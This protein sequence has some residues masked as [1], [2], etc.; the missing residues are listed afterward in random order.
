M[1]SVL[2]N[3]RK[4]KVTVFTL[5]VI[6]LVLALYFFKL[7]FSPFAFFLCGFTLTGIYSFRCYD[8]NDQKSIYSMGVSCIGAIATA[9]F[10]SFFF[11]VFFDGNIG[12]KLFVSIYTLLVVAISLIHML[13][14]NITLHILPKE[15]LIVIGQP[16]WKSLFEEISHSMLSKIVPTAYI[17]PSDDME[18]N[19]SDYPGTTG[20]IIAN[21]QYMKNA[22]VAATADELMKRGFHVKYLSETAERI[23]QRIPLNV[24]TT[25]SEYYDVALR[26]QQPKAYS[27]ACDIITSLLLMCLFSP[28]MLIIACSI[29][30]AMGSPVIFRNERIGR[31]GEPFVLYKFRTMEN[32]DDQTPGFADENLSRI[33][34]LGKFLRRTRLDELPQLW[35]VF[36]GEMSLIGPRPEQVAFDRKYER[37]IPF[38]DM[39]QR[40]RPG[41]TGWAQVNYAYASDR[42]QAAR[43]LEY[44][45][46]YVKN[47]SPLLDLEIFLKTIQ[48]MLGMRGSK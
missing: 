29:A 33:T 1:F 47:A 3:L 9:A 6:T 21:P 2:V 28:L 38:Y 15:K 25:F 31:N 34:P 35:N 43:K 7:H 37:E 8:F 11:T 20:L 39:R 36:K 4:M 48:T 27:R 14:Y 23:L 5:D 12:R 44:D 18:I 26:T 32:T 46:Y 22:K 40:L 13:G 42:E 16:S 30:F 17:V 41:I 19:L 45:L 24:C 10:A